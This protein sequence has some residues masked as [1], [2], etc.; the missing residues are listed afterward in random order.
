MRASAGPAQPPPS[1]AA[2]GTARSQNQVSQPRPRRAQCLLD[3]SGRTVRRVDLMPPPCRPL[4]RGLGPISCRR[5]RVKSPDLQGFHEVAQPGSNRRPPACKAGALPAEL[6][7]QVPR[8]L[9]R[10]AAAAR[11]ASRCPARGSAV[12]VEVAR[13]ALLEPEPVVV[14]RV[15]EEFRRLFEDVVLVLTGG[16]GL[17]SAERSRRLGWSASASARRSSS[18]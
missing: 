2:P 17:A 3:E 5:R 15:L 4:L 8:S 18:F 12:E 7:P 9:T 13:R 14:G 16:I 11:V 1:T 6:W 10:G